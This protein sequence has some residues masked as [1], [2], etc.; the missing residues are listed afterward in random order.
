MGRWCILCCV[1]RWWLALGKRVGGRRRR[2]VGVFC[3][4]DGGRGVLSLLVLWAVVSMA[5]MTRRYGACLGGYG[6]E[7]CWP[8]AY[9]CWGCVARKRR[10]RGPGPCSRWLSRSMQV[11]WRLVQ[12]ENESFRAA[13]ALSRA[14][15]MLAGGLCAKGGRQMAAVRSARGLFRR[16]NVSRARCPAVSLSAVW[17]CLAPDCS[18]TLLLLCD[19]ERRLMCAVLSRLAVCLPY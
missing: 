2:R 15:L 3:D 1:W 12:C 8:C 17:C 4:R 13:I 10:R 19:Q 6:S 11:G 5:G 16:A 18:L 7:W 9:P 14:Q